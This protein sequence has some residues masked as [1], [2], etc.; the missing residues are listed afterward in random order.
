MGVSLH[1]IFGKFGMEME[2]DLEHVSI[3]NKRYVGNIYSSKL[4]FMT[5]VLDRVIVFIV[6]YD[7]VLYRAFRIMA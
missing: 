2:M 7:V 4:S 1:C 5:A 6:N 3:G